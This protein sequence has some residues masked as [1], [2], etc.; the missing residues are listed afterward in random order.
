MLEKKERTLYRT[1][2]FESSIGVAVLVKNNY[3]GSQTKRKEG[4]LNYTNLIVKMPN[5]PTQNDSQKPT[6]K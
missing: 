5:I 4:G 3:K 2:K 6:R 1:F